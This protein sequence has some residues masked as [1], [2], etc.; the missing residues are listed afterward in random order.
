MQKDF[1]QNS[2]P[3]AEAPRLRN[4]DEDAQTVHSRSH[5]K[6]TQDEYMVPALLTEE[7]ICETRDRLIPPCSDETTSKSSNEYPRG[8]KATPE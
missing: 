7:T 2:Q 8:D 4:K 6:Q 3:C 5:R 1:F